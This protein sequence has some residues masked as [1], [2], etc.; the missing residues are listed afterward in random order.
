MIPPRSISP[1]VLSPMRGVKFAIRLD[2]AKACASLLPSPPSSWR[3]FPAL[4][5]RLIGLRRKRSTPAL[6]AASTL[7]DEPITRNHV[8]QILFTSGTTSEPRGVVLTHGNF[9]ANLE[10]LEKGID[11]YRKYERWF[12]PLRFVSARSAEPR[13]RPVHGALRAAAAGRDRRLRKLAAS[14]G[15]SSHHQT[16][17]RHRARSRC[18]ACST[19]CA[20]RMERD[21][22]A[23]GW[24]GLV[25]LCLRRRIRQ[26]ILSAPR[27]ALSPHPPPTRLEI[28]GV[29]FRRRRA[30]SPKPKNFSSAS[31]TPSCKATA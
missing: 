12:H 18:R 2:A 30:L 11:E 19:R 9:L 20:M 5:M 1:H 8:A 15:D 22:D 14:L 6:V 13:L 4:P 10:P 25:L 3:I 27:L 24:R 23:R 21:I 7:S 17:T 29:H 28:L 31:A 16:R 26:G